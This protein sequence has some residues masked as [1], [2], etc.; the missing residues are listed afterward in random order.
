MLPDSWPKVDQI[1]SDYQRHMS[2][3]LAKYQQTVDG[4]AATTEYLPKLLRLLLSAAGIR[5]Q[6]PS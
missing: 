1:I 2:C 4:G 3:R 5:A 6:R